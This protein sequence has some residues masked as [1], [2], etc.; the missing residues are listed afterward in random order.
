[1]SGV[2]LT[3]PTMGIGSTAQGTVTLTAAPTAAASITLTS[4]NPTVLTVPSPLSVAAGSSTATFTITGVAAGTASVGASL[5]G[6]TSQSPSVTVARVALST[7]T[8]SAGSVVGGNAVTGTVNLTASAPVGGAA[9]AV[10][11]SD[12][13]TAP[14]TVTVPAG[15][16]TATFNVATRLVG[17]TIVGTVTASYGGA[18]ASAGLSVTKPTVAT[19]SFGVTG[20]T[21]SDTCTIGNNGSTLNCTFNGSTSQAPGNIVAWDWSYRVATTIAQTTTGPVLTNPSVDC[22]WLPQPPLPPG[23]N[24]WLPLVITLKVRDDLGNVSAEMTNNAARVFP[25]GVCGY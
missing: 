14:G 3:V 1:M 23:A 20:P 21:E 4:S 5:N 22:G 16:T 7:M 2:T 13:I 10:T 17:G 18:S 6:S 15:A 19:A 25:Q 12:P 9:V 8:L 11:A 24:T